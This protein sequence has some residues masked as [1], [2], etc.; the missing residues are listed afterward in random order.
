MKRLKNKSV[1][2]ITKRLYILSLCCM[3]FAFGLVLTACYESIEFRASEPTSNEEIVIK[4]ALASD[5]FLSVFDYLHE[6]DYSEV[7]V[8]R[9][10]GGNT[11]RYTD[12]DNLVI[13]TNRPLLDFAVISMGHDFIGDELF[14]IPMDS[15]GLIDELLPDEAFVITNYWGMG[16]F[17]WSGVTFVD[18]D[19]I[20]RYFS[21]RQN[22]AYPDGSGYPWDIGEFYNRNDELPEDWQPWW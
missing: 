21:I 6:F 5:E 1:E 13:W 15:F 18:E 17:P 20:N 11:A 7:L 8:S 4:V 9:I 19:G 12:G 2:G 16:A 22:H 10:H 3:L 14:F